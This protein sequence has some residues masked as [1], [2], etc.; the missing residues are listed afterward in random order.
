MGTVVQKFGGSS[1]SGHEHV[2]R[3]AET[4]R[5]TREKGVVPVVC[6]SARG[7]TTDDLIAE[8]ARFHAGNKRELDQLLSTGEIASAAYTA[9]A[10]AARGV[11]AVSLTGQQAGVSATG[12][13]DE[14][15][16]SD[17]EPQRILAHVREGT[18][19]V[20]AGF[21]GMDTIGD[22]RTLGRGGSDT[23]AVALAAKLGADA[24]EIHT[25]V[26]GIHTA[27]PRIVPNARLIPAIP[28][29]V[30]HEM[31][32]SGARV[33]HARAAELAA[34]NGVDISV[35]NSATRT[36][37]T[38]IPGRG[39]E[40]LE[41]T[42]FTVAVTHDTN[43]ARVLVHREGPA[44]DLGQIVLEL[45]SERLL[46]IDLL[47]WVG[48]GPR[49]ANTGFTVRTERLRDTEDALSEAAR[50]FDLSYSVSTGLGQVSLVGIGLLNRP[51]YT[52]RILRCLHGLGITA[53]WV[54][55]TQSRTTVLVPAERTGEATA[56]VHDEFG[57]GEPDT[58]G[59]MAVPT[60]EGIQQ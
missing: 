4:I 10:L 14:I 36:H 30:M 42:G 25:D 12:S 43:I 34:A 52:A 15:R 5:R 58:A 17:I 39:E 27:D 38:T 11:P 60:R 55:T 35:H 8:S 46:P 32:I 50:K 59:S 54:S 3:T 20:V 56:A 9:M 22:I 13:R 28:P 45:L 53:D 37:G 29:G 49:G 24:C 19:V 6:V 18:V 26:D 40:M 31:A 44:H 57:L 7:D 33:I 2:M 47:G 41:N 51:D 1:L 23:T 21:Q 16:I 48:N